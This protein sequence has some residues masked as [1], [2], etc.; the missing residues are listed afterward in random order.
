VQTESGAKIM[1]DSPVPRIAFRIVRDHR[2]ELETGFLVRTPSGACWA[3]PD[4]E[5]IDQDPQSVGAI[6]L[7][8]RHLEE[9]QRPPGEPP[10]F[11]YREVLHDHQSEVRTPP[12][13]LG[14]R[15]KTKNRLN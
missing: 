8:A 2:L 6:Q 4:E 11:L 15:P 5:T 12:S 13:L 3:F 9:Q 10:L 14:L 1:T 7:D